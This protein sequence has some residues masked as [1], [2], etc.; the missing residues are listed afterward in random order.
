MRGRWL[1]ARQAREIFDGLDGAHRPKDLTVR[2]T[3]QRADVAAPAIRLRLIVRQVLDR[4]RGVT[5]DVTVEAGDPMLG[6]SERRSSMRLNAGCGTGAMSILMP[7]HS[8]A[9]NMDLNL[10]W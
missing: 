5:V 2:Q 3:A 7:L 4:A 6:R 8:W 9:F 1:S 10:S